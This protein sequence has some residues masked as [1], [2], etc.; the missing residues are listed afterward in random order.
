MIFK[1]KYLKKKDYV[2]EKRE[3]LKKAVDNLDKRY[4]NHE[5]EREPFLKLLDVFSKRH[6]KLLKE[7][8]KD[9]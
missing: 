6:I 3:G 5:V 1:E 2:E 8:K 9:K 4:K 7:N